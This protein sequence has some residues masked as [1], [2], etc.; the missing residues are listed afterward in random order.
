MLLCAKEGVKGPN[1]YA[2][3][4][5]TTRES[6][7]KSH[8]MATRWHWKQSVTPFDNK[9]VLTEYYHSLAYGHF[10]SPKL[11]KSFKSVMRNK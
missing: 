1:V 4:I 6:G 7:E 2:M 5:E 9:R 8:M 11:V 3:T 10:Q